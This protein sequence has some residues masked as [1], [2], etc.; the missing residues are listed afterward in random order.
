MPSRVW[1]TS[2]P[3]SEACVSGR[4]LTRVRVDNC[5]DAQLLANIELVVDKVPFSAVVSK[6]QPDHGI[7]HR[8]FGPKAS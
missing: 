2:L 6:R 8:L 5:Q 1:A 4:A 3:I 7:A